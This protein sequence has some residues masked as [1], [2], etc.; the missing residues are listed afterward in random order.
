LLLAKGKLGAGDIG[1][2]LRHIE[3]VIEIDNQHIEANILYALVSFQVGNVKQAYGTLEE[4]IA[5]NFSI[6][7]SPLFMMVKGEIELMN[8]DNE[9]AL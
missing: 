3:R 8:N 7:E 6:R 1:A 5:N 2:A 9:A 4:A